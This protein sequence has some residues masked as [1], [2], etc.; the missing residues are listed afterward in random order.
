MISLKYG[1]I[2]GAILIIGIYFA[3]SISAVKEP[4]EVNPN[5]SATY[6][7]GGGFTNPWNGKYIPTDGFYIMGGNDGEWYQKT[8][9]SEAE[10][11]VT[12]GAASLNSLSIWPDGGNATGGAN[13]QVYMP[14][15]YPC[16]PPS[17]CNNYNAWESAGKPLYTPSSGWASCG[18]YTNPRSA[19]GKTNVRGP[20]CEDDACAKSIG[21]LPL[22]KWNIAVD[23]DVMRGA[24]PC[25][26]TIGPPPTLETPLTCA[27]H[28]CPGS[29]AINTTQYCIKNKCTDAQC[30][31][32][33][34]CKSFDCLQGWQKKAGMDSTV[35]QN[36]KCENGFCCEE[37]KKCGGF[38][39]PKGYH[40]NSDVAGDD[41]L[42]NKCAKEQCCIQ[43][44]CEYTNDK[45]SI[46]DK[47]FFLNPDKM[48]TP[49]G[50]NCDNKTCCLPNP[51]C[52]DSYTKKDFKCE[53]NTYYSK[54]KEGQQCGQEICTS[55]ECC[56]DEVNCGSILH[57][58]EFGAR[59]GHGC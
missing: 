4:L 14:Y 10:N 21:T 34:V 30:C 58:G 7:R 3:Y 25:P 33:P 13:L 6:V 19:T 52:G 26:P 17:T 43:D 5:K 18:L 40:T 51:L 27:D 53:D 32:P 39:C 59:L 9:D 31:G 15:I 1:I 38:P 46:C 55:G 22:G 45:K 35:C 57:I 41:C 50:P 16:S 48:N 37:I 29:N 44:T 36:N 56:T 54:S 8:W 42:N 20:G 2:L 24:D 47:L 12:E 11:A 23:G 49:C 28:S